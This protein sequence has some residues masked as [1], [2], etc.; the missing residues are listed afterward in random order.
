MIVMMMAV[1][2]FIIVASSKL[3][4]MDLPIICEAAVA[5]LNHRSRST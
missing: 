5:K 1:T 4:M 3:S 2:M